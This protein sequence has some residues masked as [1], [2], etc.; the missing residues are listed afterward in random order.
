MPLPR[1]ARALLLGLRDASLGS[2]DAVAAG[3]SAVLRSPATFPRSRRLLQLLVCSMVPILM[4]VA[5]F[6]ALR[7]Q[8]RIRTADPAAYALDACLKQLVA[9]DKKGASRLTAEQRQQRDDIEIYIAEHLREGAEDSASYAAAFPGAASFRYQYKMAARA[10]E[11]HP[12]RSPEQVKRAEET[13][14]RLLAGTTV[15]VTQLNRPMVLWGVLA[16]IAAGSA[17]FVAVLGL[18][19]ALAVRGG[20]TMRAFGAALVRADGRD[21][22]RLR[23]LVRALVAWSPVLLFPLL[24][25]FGPPLDRI[26]VGFA[27][28][29]T[30][31]PVMLLAGAV[32]AWKHPSRG[33]QDRIAGTW[34]VP[35]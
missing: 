3:A 32:W 21:A 30:L 13:V 5:V 9:L 22:S 7:W 33:I 26:T 20:F 28:L 25:K 16:M 15:A 23:A 19:G 2:G 12:V 10:L 29:Y 24:I 14:A 35:R 27:F 34:I 31:V 17:A 1:P 6:S 11:N 8:L 4:V 18:I